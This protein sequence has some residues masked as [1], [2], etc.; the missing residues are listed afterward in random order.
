MSLTLGALIALGAISSAATAAAN[1]GS[2]IYMNKQNIAMMREQNAF[3]SAEARLQRDFSSSE[4]AKQRAWEEN[5]SNTAYQRSMADMEAAGLNPILAASNGGAGTP[6]G[7]V[8]QGEAAHSATT[9]HLS[10]PE[11]ADIVTNSVLK[12]V[13]IS[14]MSHGDMKSIGFGR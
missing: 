1:V 2:T 11:F 13:M 8:A 6:V 10:A 4:A 3:N 12:A 7:S 14:N 9:A 5:M